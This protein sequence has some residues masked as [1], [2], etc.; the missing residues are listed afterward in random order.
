MTGLLRVLRRP[1]T[2][3][4]TAQGT[5][6]LAGLALQVAAAR[7]LGAGGLATFALLYGVIVLATAVCSGLVGDSLTVLDRHEPRTRAGLL[8]G[9]TWVC[10]AA[11]VGGALLGVLTGVVPPWAGP[12]LG[13]ATAAFVAEDALRRLLMATGRFWSLPAVDGTS[14]LLALGTLGLLRLSG[15]LDLTD[16]LLAL[17][18]GQAGAALVAWP[19]LPAHE[20]P[21]GPWRRPALRVV[22]AFGVW[23][24]AAQAIRPALLTV[25]RLLVVALAGAAAYGPLEAA[26]VYT[27]PTLVLVAGLGSWLLPHFVSLQAAGPAAGLRY[28][29][30]AAAA[31]ALAVAALGG[32]AVLVLPW[33]GP[34]LTGGDYPVPVG[35]VV[36]WTAYALASAVLL[37][38]SGLASVH[39]RQRRVLALRS[40]ELLSLVAVLALVLLV[41]GGVGWAPAALALGPLLAAV[42]VRRLVLVPLLSVPAAAGTTA[43]PVPA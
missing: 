12:V 11:G 24:A 37:P 31:L 41:P 3:A 23:R 17:L 40:L 9:A 8:V 16:F 36:G 43:A 28:A 42:A 2:G 7:S 14:L 32:A 39:R 30:R 15:A 19:L 13:L 33:L 18:V 34:A 25:L 38:Y 5:Q 26:R 6:A 29:D 1:A 4:L 20:R 22:A 21:R 27:A 35:A 10:G